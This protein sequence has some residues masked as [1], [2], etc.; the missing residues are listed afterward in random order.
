M[1]LSV[2]SVIYYMILK[3]SSQ[4]QLV[5]SETLLANTDEEIMNTQLN[6]KQIRMDFLNSEVLK[7]IDSIK[8]KEKVMESL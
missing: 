8:F 5:Q 7:N 6:T 4:S 3:R 1:C 2:I